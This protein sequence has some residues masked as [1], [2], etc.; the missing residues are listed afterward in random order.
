MK[1]EG[2]PSAF[3]FVLQENE[4]A[5]RFYA[6]H[7]FAWDGTSADIP[8]PNSPPCHDLRYVKKL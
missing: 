7:G 6:A 1:L 2:F 5:R 3:V 4:G 8:F